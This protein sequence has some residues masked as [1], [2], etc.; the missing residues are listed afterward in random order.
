MIKL[1]YIGVFVFTYINQKQTEV[2]KM[3]TSKRITSLIVAL[4]FALT[5][6]LSFSVF[7]DDLA[8]SDVT[9]TH[10]YFSAISELVGRGV[11]N[12]Y[13]DG[14]FKPDATITRAEFAKLLAVATAPAG[15]KFEAT[16]TQFPD[17][18]DANSS[19]AWAIPY[20]A[21]AVGTK[22]INGYEDGTFRPTAP[23]SYGE[24][25]KMIVCT[26]G[27][28]DV[29]NKNLDPWYKGY[30]DVAN[31]IG[32]TKNA[33]LNGAQ[34]APRGVVAQ[35]IYNIDFCSKLNNVGFNENKDPIF[36]QGGSTGG[37]DWDNSESETGKLL[38]V[39]EYSLTGKRLANTEV[40]IGDTV[41]EI[42]NFDFDTLKGMVGYSVSFK[43]STMGRKTLTSINKVSGMNSSF[44]I[45][46]WQI[47]D[48]SAETI[49]YFK[50]EDDKETD[51]ISKVTLSDNL[52]VV[53]NEVPVHPDFIDADFI[54]DY[55]NVENGNITLISNDG[56]SS[57]AEIAVVESYVS[58]YVSSVVKNNG[59]V[60][61]YDKYSSITGL[62]KLDFDEHDVASVRRITSKG[63]SYSE[64]TIDAISQKSVVSIAQPY[65]SVEGTNVIISTATVTGNV[66]EMSSDYEYVKIGT[67]SYSASPYYRTILAGGA[68][69]AFSTG[70]SGKF[71]LDY[72]GRIVAFEKK[73]DD[74]PYGLLIRYKHGSGMDASYSVEIYTSSGTILQAPIKESVRFNGESVSAQT[75]I[76]RLLGTRSP[77]AKWDLVN[78]DDEPVN[79]DNYLIQPIRYKTSVSGG[80]TY[81][82]EIEAMDS[83]NDYQDGLIVPAYPSIGNFESGTPGENL[84]Y[85]KSGY[86]FKQDSSNV[87]AMG[88]KTILF[89]VPNDITKTDSY[90]KGTYT[91]S[92]TD[93][94]QYA[95]EAYNVD[96]GNA[97]IVI[98]YPT[99]SNTGATIGAST[100]TYLINSATPA[101][102]PDGSD[103]IKVTFYR[104]GNAEPDA[105][106]KYIKGDY[107]ASDFDYD[108][109]DLKSGDVVKMTVSGQYITNIKPVYIDGEL[110]PDTG[111]GENYEIDGH[112]V[113][114][115]YSGT[116]DYYQ[117]MLGVVYQIEGTSFRVIPTFAYGDDFDAF[118]SS[119]GLTLSDSVAYYKYNTKNSFEPSSDGEIMTYAELEESE[120]PVEE[121]TK[122]LAIG[123]EKKIVAVLIVE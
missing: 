78:E 8:F 10:T 39:G 82:S 41:Y 76:N 47:E 96:K 50:N 38:G 81:V 75:A 40:L 89:V 119:M 62:A 92:F 74:V 71:Y 105:D 95:V 66:K 37:G 65:G 73:V 53:Y 107:K 7:A 114:H 34:P 61:I 93:G 109:E 25:I 30:V 97:E 45:D 57:S 19:S 14:T 70:D 108:P 21:Y 99:T 59:T 115:D 69:V 5:S 9:E 83:S 79:L 26:M 27:Y 23:V 60:S 104:A 6:M 46:D 87:F 120:A 72:Q 110:L 28:G 4:V 55:L 63:G 22:A 33:Y 24:V 17:V 2:F 16:T 117:A 11:I 48:V 113:K 84:T 80:K 121:S 101:K 68:D 67:E 31:S 58:Y 20:I 116:K 85:S 122:V 90:R 49:K 103:A 36:V 44:T 15:T 100:Y 51:K 18:A 77:S 98:Y 3:K 35:L 1:H 118:G 86:Y 112:Y 12:G 54:E 64:T 42:G 102:G 32:L 111:T 88:T 123:R 52:Y 56:S 29:V 94:K 91:Y 106:P 43:F 13:E